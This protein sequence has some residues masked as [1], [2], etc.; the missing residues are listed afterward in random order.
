MLKLIGKF[1]VDSGQ[2]M[3]G[4]P[5]YLDSWQTWESEKE[6]F[7]NHKNKKGEFSYLGACNATLENSYGELGHGSAVVFNTGFG[8][9]SY[10][11]Y[12]Q[13]NE[14]IVEKIVIDFVGTLDDEGNEVDNYYA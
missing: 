8:D 1:G 6:P 10:P 4:D 7:E 14:G 5:C 11:V 13:I 9:G 12:A 2:A 3:I